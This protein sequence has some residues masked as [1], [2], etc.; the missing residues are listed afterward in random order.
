MDNN[1]NSAGIKNE[2][3]A[4]D[5]FGGEDGANQFENME[6]SEIETYYKV[7]AMAASLRISYDKALEIHEMTA[8]KGIFSKT[9]EHQE[10]EELCLSPKLLEYAI[11]VKELMQKSEPTREDFD[12]E[13]I[14]VPD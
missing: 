7:K 11:K 8:K 9:L 1:L 10:Q 13:V 3:D 5:E 12:E 4:G 2:S 14:Y 6:Q